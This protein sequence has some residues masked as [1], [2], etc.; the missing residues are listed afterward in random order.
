MNWL[1]TASL[2]WV[3]QSAGE[4]LIALLQSER[5]KMKKLSPQRYPLVIFLSQDLSAGAVVILRE[6]FL[7]SMSAPSPATHEQRTCQGTA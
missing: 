5:A 3:K 2:A 1:S 4:R 7:I 6:M